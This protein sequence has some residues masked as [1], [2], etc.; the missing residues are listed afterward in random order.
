MHRVRTLAGLGLAAGAAAAALTIGAASAANRATYRDCSFVGG[1]DPDFVQ[2]SGA[3]AG[4]GGTLTV[5][6]SQSQVQVLASESSD[7]GD[8]S[9]RDTLSVTVT[10]PNTAAH[11]VSG[12]GTGKVSLAVPLSGAAAGTSYTISWMAT[13]DNENHSC[14][15]SQTPQ[16]ANANPFVLSVTTPTGG[17]SGGA[18]P[19]GGTTPAPTPAPRKHSTKSKCHTRTERVKGHTRRVR[20]CRGT[21]KHHHK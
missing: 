14:P 16:N 11:T 3:T 10:A 8:S 4:P 9:G 15:S 13:F 17:G 5:P 12:A 20:V 19:G 2:L 7:P 21:R 18:N 1:L 6:A